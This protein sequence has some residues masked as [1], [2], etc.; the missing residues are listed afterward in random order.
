MDIKIDEIVKQVIKEV[1]T[2]DAAKCGNIPP[3]TERIPERA[4]A[5]YLTEPE[6]Y[7]IK[8][9]DMP[10]PGEKEILVRMEGCIV[11]ETDAQEFLKGIPGYQCPAIGE[12]GTGRVIK[13]GGSDVK[14]VHGRVIKEGDV[15][16]ALGAV[17][18]K[19]AG[20]GDR[21]REAR[22]CGWYS[23]YVILRE[24][25]QIL[26]MNGMDLDSRMLYR[27]A[28]DAAASM[29]RICKLYKPEKYAKIAVAGCQS[30][31]LLVIAALKCA[32]F[33][34]IIAIDDS[35]ERLALAM[36]LGARHKAAFSCRNGM[37]GMVEKTKECFGGSL[38]DLVL[39]CVELPGGMSIARRFA[40]NGG[41]T[42]DLTKR[43]RTRL[44]KEAYAQG[45]KVLSLAQTAQIPLYRL[46]THRFHLEEINEANW[47]VLS[48][49]GHVCA[50]LNR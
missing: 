12:E 2:T 4:K 13:T 38:A 50:L 16:T 42:A 10:V 20:Y 47:T 37:Q 30:M 24:D 41:N 14:D 7:E 1:K 34:D 39:Q 23:S 49:K 36:K 6:N 15:V 22:P 35:E 32:G 29:S 19:R 43:V 40:G 25:M 44:T 48:G 3:R 33:S 9:F 31:G 11:P 27:Q 17:N 26:Q 28:C 8:T 5:A 18:T 46:I 45:E 21:Q